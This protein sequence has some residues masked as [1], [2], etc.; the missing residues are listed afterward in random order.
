MPDA[1]RKIAVVT[2]AS[3]GIGAATARRLAADGYQVVLAARRL[4]RLQ[5]LAAEID[6]VAV[7]CDITNQADVDALAAQFPTIHVL[8]NNAGGA[9]GKATVMESDEG[10]WRTMWETNVLGTMGCAGHWYQPSS[11][12]VTVSSSPSPR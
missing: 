1:S 8:V 10:Q 5:D 3:S 2:G 12:P 7:R 9:H 6:G 4:D 11:P